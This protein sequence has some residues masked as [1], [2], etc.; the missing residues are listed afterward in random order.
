MSYRLLLL[1]KNGHLVGHTTVNCLDDEEAI[2]V[3]KHKVR[4]CEYV[5]VWRGGRP[6][7]MCAR[8]LDSSPPWKQQA[9]RVTLTPKQRRRRPGWKTG[10]GR[11][12]DADLGAE[13]G[14]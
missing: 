14:V 5:E 7:C 10:L 12:S 9:S 4:K 2:A 13:N 6:V 1:A 3:A 11:H 8:S